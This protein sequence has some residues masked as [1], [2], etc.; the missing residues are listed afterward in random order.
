VDGALAFGNLGVT[1]VGTCRES[2]VISRAD[3]YLYAGASGATIEAPAGGD[4]AL[5]LRGTHVKITGLTVKGGLYIP[6]GA[7]VTVSSSRV[8]GSGRDGIFMNGGTLVLEGST[9]DAHQASGVFAYE[10][11]T[12]ILR[13]STI[14]NNQRHGVWLDMATAV[15]DR[16]RIR[17]NPRNG[18]GL[19]F[20]STAQVLSSTIENN[21]H[22]YL[23]SGIEVGVGS[24]L[25]LG[26]AADWGPNVIRRNVEGI[27]VSNGSL[28]TAGGQLPVAII[29]ESSDAGV[30][31]N[32]PTGNTAVLVEL[33]E[34]IVLENNVI[35]TN[36]PG[37]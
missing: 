10:G 33:F 20:G 27:T 18:L 5:V 26:T 21:G 25:S 13:D 2:V 35:D 36:C 24:R 4:F 31:C 29:S 6:S 37:F 34:S 23:W 8:T 30:D 3:T 12:V 1:V 17:N 19:G 28:A 9:V 11:S 14:E 16:C 7:H 22:E 32:P 15:V